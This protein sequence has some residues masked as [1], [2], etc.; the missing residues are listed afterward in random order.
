MAN[1]S[2]DIG[3]SRKSSLS[4]FI[5]AGHLTHW[6]YCFNSDLYVMYWMYFLLPRKSGRCKIGFAKVEFSGHT[7]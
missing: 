6:M 5:G 3:P 4:E 7:P 2:T 1:F